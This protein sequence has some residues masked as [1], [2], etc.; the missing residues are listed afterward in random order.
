MAAQKI[1]SGTYAV[2]DDSGFMAIV[3]PDAYDG[4]VGADWETAALVRKFQDQMAARSLLIWGTGMESTWTVAVRAWSESA[5]GFR[6][7][8]GTIRSS[9]GRLL[10]TNYE[11][12]TMAAQFENIQLPEP[13]QADLV[14]LVE[15]GSYRCRITQI[16]DP[17]AEPTESESADFLI[18]LDAYAEPEPAWQAIPWSELR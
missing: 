5:N 10:L 16:R 13:H 12:L 2:T 3:D 7:C 11:S 1:Q 15:P 6:Q 8:T 17:D 9:R 4:F 18:E 14:L